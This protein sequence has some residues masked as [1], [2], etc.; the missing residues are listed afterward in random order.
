MVFTILDVYEAIE[1]SLNLWRESSP[2]ATCE[3]HH[4][5]RRP[6]EHFTKPGTIWDLMPPERDPT[7][8]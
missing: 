3:P 2:K 6:V 4:L 8:M 7:L 5:R 1:E